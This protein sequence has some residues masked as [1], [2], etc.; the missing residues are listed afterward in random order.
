MV[1]QLETSWRMQLGDEFDASYFKALMRFL[2]EREDA[3]AKVLPPKSLWFSA[4]SQTRFAD[5]KVVIL[6][7]DPYHAVGQA[8]GLCF[9]V[10]PN[11]KIPPSLK[12]IYKELE[13]DLKMP[14]PMHGCLESWAAQGVLLLN[15][16]LTVEEGQAGAHQ[17]RGWEHFTD[18]V[19]EAINTERERVVFMLWGAQ[20]Q[21]KGANINAQRH[22][23]LQAPHPSPLSAHRGFL[24]CGHFSAANAYLVSHGVQPIDWQLLQSSEPEFQL[25]P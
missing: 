10:L 11:V 3:G 16:V 5:V 13:R 12:N 20:A 14:I 2:Q 4:L 19:I 17:N 15:T 24:G 23:V 6:G 7:Q 25:T 9:S 1:E 8:H 21:K 22:L 18:A